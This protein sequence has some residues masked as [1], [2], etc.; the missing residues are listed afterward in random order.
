[1]I[2]SCALWFGWYLNYAR[3]FSIATAIAIFVFLIVQINGYYFYP[4][5]IEDLNVDRIYVEGY[6]TAGSRTS[7]TALFSYSINES[8]RILYR[9]VVN[10]KHFE[11]A[12]A[13]GKVVE[14][15]WSYTDGP[16]LAMI[17]ET[18]FGDRNLYY[19]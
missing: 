1:M 12:K 19:A 7:R 17:S 8:R 13:A 18:F 5:K 15:G 4:D 6:G 3:D 9:G 16:L 10:N 14:V 2:L 11:E